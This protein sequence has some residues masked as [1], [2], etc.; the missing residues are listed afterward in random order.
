MI[1]AIG[2]WRAGHMPGEMGTITNT[3]ALHVN[4][5]YRLCCSPVAHT[6]QRI[7]KAAN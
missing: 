2:K 6:A 5:V 4:Y 3:I 7:I 1:M